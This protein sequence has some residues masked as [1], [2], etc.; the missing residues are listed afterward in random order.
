MFGLLASNHLYESEIIKAFKYLYDSGYLYKD[1]KSDLWCINCMMDLSRSEV[2]YRNHNLL[3]VYVKFPVIKGL[4]S[5]GV[6]VFILIWTNVPWI[7]FENR[8][9]TLHPD[10][11]YAAVKTEDHGVLIMAQDTVGNILKRKKNYSIIKTMKGAELGNIV[12]SH[13]LVDHD[14]SIL[15]D[16]RASAKRGTGCVYDIPKHNQSGFKKRGKSE[17]ASS[18][19]QYGYL[20][21]C[22]GRFYGH[23]VFE[24]AELISLELEKRGYLFS[25][26]HAEYKHPQCSYCK[27][28]IIVIA[29]EHWFVDLDANHLRQRT[30]KIADEIAWLPGWM[31]NRISNR[32]MNMP[33]WAI[34]RRGSTGLPIPV[35]H[36]SDCESQLDIAMTVES[37]QE[38]MDKDI[39]CNNCGGKKI[40]C[41]NDIFSEEFIY[42]LSHFFTKKDSLPRSCHYMIGSAKTEGLIPF[43]LISSITSEEGSPIQSCAIN[44]AIA[45]NDSS[46]MH[47]IDSLINQYGADIVRLLISSL[48]CRRHPKISQIQIQ[49]VKSL[50]ARI[51]NTCRFLTGNLSGYDSKKDRVSYEHLQEVDRWMLHKLT[52]LVKEVTRSLDNWQFHRIIRHIYNFCSI[53]LNSVYLSIVKRRLYTSPRWSSSRRASQTV[54]YEVVTTI[55]KLLA[56]ILPFTAE[57]IWEYIPEAKSEYTSIYLSDWPDVQESYFDEELEKR[58]DLLLK[59]RS[60]IYKLQAK[61]DIRNLSEASVIFYVS[62]TEIHSIL[63]NYIDNLEEI[64]GISKA[65][66]MPPEIPVPDGIEWPNDLDGIA[67]E[68]RLTNG[69]KCERCWIYSDTVGT[70]DQYPTLCYKCIAAIEGST[71]YV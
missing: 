58:W 54:I 31:K 67:L 27:S 36:C 59:I 42:V 5:L 14:L 33:D 63:D 3:S 61:S 66:L 20:T 13:P 60:H 48:D 40:K 32:I 56:P 18:V 51:R 44:R 30:M 71:Y 38:L 65:R 43:Y 8:S 64:F 4:E 49:Q 57:E 55:A 12:C 11:E 47:T 34:S 25:S 68:I 7:L 22:T 1:L 53:H 6:D 35:F 37:Y 46:E 19:D 52:D 70:N 50:H 69:N 17:I 23:K 21:G 28:P 39:T 24:S 10:L 2:E 29:N 62:S 15:L 16:K 26:D 41:G 9:I 45:F